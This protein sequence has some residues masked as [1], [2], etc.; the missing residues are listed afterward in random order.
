MGTWGTWAF[1]FFFSFFLL[2]VANMSQKE[3]EPDSLRP[4]ANLCSSLEW[5]IREKHGTTTRYND[6]YTINQY[7]YICVYMYIYIHDIM[8]CIQHNN[9][10]IYICIY[11]Y[12][13]GACMADDITII[14]TKF[15]PSPGVHLRRRLPK[16][17]EGGGLE[18]FPPTLWQGSLNG[19]LNAW[20]WFHIMTPFCWQF[21]AIF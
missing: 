16:R 2:N 18:G 14:L 4:T 6:I 9:T 11:W 20:G 10:T 12:E 3:T 19:M 15:P 21:T 8:I 17:F 5:I 7:I 1:A 13:I